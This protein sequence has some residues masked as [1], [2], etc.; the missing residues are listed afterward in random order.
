MD[1]ARGLSLLE[2]RREC[3]S[4]LGIAGDRADH[5]ESCGQ[6]GEDE[7]HAVAVFDM[8]V[9]RGKNL[10]GG[11]WGLVISAV[12]DCTKELLGTCNA[13]YLPYHPVSRSLSLITHATSPH[14]THHAQISDPKL[15]Q[16]RAETPYQYSTNTTGIPSPHHICPGPINTHPLQ[17]Q[18]PF[19]PQK[20]AGSFS[21]R[22]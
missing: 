10:G 2:Q 15:A 13:G 11:V 12:S 20:S 3:Q 1:A 7:V 17:P 14:T 6:E 19:S 9:R 22:T 16:N 18:R 5:K 8:A 21:P 4:G